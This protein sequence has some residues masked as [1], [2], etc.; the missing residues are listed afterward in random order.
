MT[1]HQSGF[2]RTLIRSQRCPEEV[3]LKMSS[4]IVLVSYEDQRGGMNFLSY[5]IDEKS[6]SGWMIEISH[7]N[8]RKR[9]TAISDMP[10]NTQLSGIMGKA[11]YQELNSYPGVSLKNDHHQRILSLAILRSIRLGLANEYFISKMKAVGQE[12]LGH[13]NSDLNLGAG[14]YQP[15]IPISISIHCQATSPKRVPSWEPIEGFRYR[16]KIQNQDD[17]IHTYQEI[18]R[19]Y[20]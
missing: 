4:L 10:N 1:F 3:A 16:K 12:F 2:R 8:C 18:D 7:H 19:L 17:N 15:V 13:L 9:T 11:K 20:S 5:G 14:S 6:E